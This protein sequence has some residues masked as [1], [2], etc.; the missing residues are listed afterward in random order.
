MI[1][2]Y[3]Y[4]IKKKYCTDNDIKYIEISYKDNKKINDII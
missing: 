3:E 2:E 1:F 4:K